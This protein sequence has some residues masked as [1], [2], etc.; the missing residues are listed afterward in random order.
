MG[1]K[2]GISK[3]MEGMGPKDSILMIDGEGEVVGLWG[4]CWLVWLVAVVWMLVCSSRVRYGWGDG[5][6]KE[7]VERGDTGHPKWGRMGII[8]EE[9]WRRT[10]ETEGNLGS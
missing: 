5:R 7:N 10:R 1:H 9:I 6:C 2:G 8:E 4:L 3:A